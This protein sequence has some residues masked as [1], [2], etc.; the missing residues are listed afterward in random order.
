MRKILDEDALADVLLQGSS[1]KAAPYHIEYG[2]KTYGEIKRL[3]RKKP[4]DLKARQMKK[5]I[6]QGAN[7]LSQ[8]PKRPRGRKPRR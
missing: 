7:R 3:A 4:P 2:N 5:L 1:K 6:E 8:K